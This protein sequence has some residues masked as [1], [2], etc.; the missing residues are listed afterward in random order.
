VKITSQIFVPKLL[1][2][3]PICEVLFE[4]VIGVWFLRHHMVL[5]VV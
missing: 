5:V 1:I 4:N 3:G 2:F